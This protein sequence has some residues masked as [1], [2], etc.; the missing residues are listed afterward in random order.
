MMNDSLTLAQLLAHQELPPLEA[1]RYA[2][3]LGEALRQIHADGRAHGA[4]SPSA[5]VVTS[6][7]LELLPVGSEDARRFQA[8]EIAEGHAPDACS[9][10]YSL[11]AILREMVNEGSPSL[12]RLVS[13]C[14]AEDRA[15]RYQRI[16]HVLMELKLAA[17]SERRAEGGPSQQQRMDLRE[18]EARWAARFERLERTVAESLQAAVAVTRLEQ[19]VRSQAVAIEMNANSMTRID[20]LVERVVEALESLQGLV[21]EQATEERVSIVK[22]A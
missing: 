16:Q 4:L 17:A 7:G 19:T 20:D 12:E 1:L 3:L 13:T 22:V 21:L 15:Q 11:G 14:L 10:I 2:A 9:D 6:E 8:P 18:I 5:V